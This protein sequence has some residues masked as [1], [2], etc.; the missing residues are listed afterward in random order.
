[1]SQM[2]W[3]LR[4]LHSPNTHTRANERRKQIHGLIKG[5]PV[6]SSAASLQAVFINAYYK[7]SVAIFQANRNYIYEIIDL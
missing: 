2:S 1:M 5:F 4:C 3:F 6:S 7:V